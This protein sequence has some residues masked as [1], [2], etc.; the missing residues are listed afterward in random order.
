MLASLFY[1]IAVVT[2]SANEMQRVLKRVQEL[3][4]KL[5][6]QTKTP[7]RDYVAVLP[8]LE[9]TTTLVLAAGTQCYTNGK[10]AE[11]AIWYGDRS[12]LTQEVGGRTICRVGGVITCGPLQVITRVAGQQISYRAKIQSK[13]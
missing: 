6:F 11:G 10:Q 5:G 7:L 12:K 9:G 3:S 13:K 8:Q 4:L 2:K 1:D